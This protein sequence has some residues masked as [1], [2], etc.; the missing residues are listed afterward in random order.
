M[1]AELKSPEKDGA[2]ARNFLSAFAA[3][4]FFVYLS[5]RTEADTSEIVRALCA[6]GK[7]VCAPRLVG[8]EMIAAPYTEALVFNGYGIREPATG[9]DEP[10]EIVVA[11]LLAADREGYRLG[12]GGGYYDRYFSAHPN[13]LRVG[14]CYEGQ[15]TARLPRGRFDLPLHK[16]VTERGVYAYR[17]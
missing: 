9:G 2:I 8:R 16:I 5:F 13:A 14:L 4:S 12:Y 11:P 1:R 10:C 17:D 3:E 7:K 6:Q 15:L